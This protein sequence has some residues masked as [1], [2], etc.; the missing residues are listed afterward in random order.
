MQPGAAL[1][2]HPPVDAR[3]GACARRGASRCDTWRAFTGGVRCRAAQQAAWAHPSPAFL[4]L[5]QTRARTRACTFG[6][7]TVL[8]THAA[9]LWDGRRVEHSCKAVEMSP[10]HVCVHVHAH[11]RAGVLPFP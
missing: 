3:G 7:R 6:P 2:R 9:R 5:P 1:E 4:S 8:P 10:E 11:A